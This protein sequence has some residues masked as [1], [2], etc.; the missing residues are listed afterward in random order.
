MRS[1]NFGLGNFVYR[2]SIGRDYYRPVRPMT[3]LDFLDRTAAHGVDRV[4]IC[5][6]I[7]LE[8]FAPSDL[9]ALKERAQHYG[10][11]LELGGRGHAPD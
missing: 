4:M 6:N 2:W 7:P 1:M 10:I 9:L 3:V 11:T 8:S 5:N